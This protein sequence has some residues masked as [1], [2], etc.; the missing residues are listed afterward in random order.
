MLRVSL[1]AMFSLLL[2]VTLLGVGCSSSSGPDGVSA[3]DGYWIEGY[4]MHIPTSQPD[5]SWVPCAVFI[6]S[7]SSSGDAVSGVNV[8]FN[9][10]ALAFNGTMYTADVTPVAPGEDVTFRISSGG[11]SASW[12]ESVPSPPTN[13][14]LVEGDWDFSSP[15]GT[16]TL[17][18][19]NPAT[20][21]DS[22]LVTVT[23]HGSHPLD[24]GSCTT[25]LDPNTTEVVLSNASMVDF[26]NSQTIECAVAQAKVGELS[27]HDG[28]SEVW[29]RAAATDEWAK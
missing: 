4:Y 8:T 10:A 6:R 1:V 28:Y 24:F 3:L 15:S 27:G 11:H 2:A 22:I 19:E 12:T 5:R 16:H 26:N 14:V 29:V 20:V 13:L 7:G 17:S 18:W 23:G 9:G 21:A 25:V